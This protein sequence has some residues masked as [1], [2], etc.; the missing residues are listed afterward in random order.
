MKTRSHFLAAVLVIAIAFPSLG[1]PPDKSIVAQLQKGGFVLFMRHGKTDPDQADTDPLHLDNIQAQRQLTDEGRQQAR[2][3]GE[4][5]RALKIPV[6]TVTCSKFNRAQETAKL[7]GFSTPQPSL[8][9]SEAGLVVSTRENQRRAQAL[10]ELLSTP[11]PAG[12]N[13]FIVSHRP[14]LQDAA[15]KEFGDLSEAEVVIFRPLGSGKFELVA[16]V[17]PVSV[18]T[19]WAKR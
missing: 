19:E 1:A 2:A 10:S 9:V 4:A 16:R 5:F 8:D 14:N 6:G 11:P 15:G 17:A 12:S 13:H 7:L 3:L 18:W